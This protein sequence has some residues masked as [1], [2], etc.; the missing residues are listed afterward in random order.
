ML[1]PSQN[2]VALGTKHREIIPVPVQCLSLVLNTRRHIT[3]IKYPSLGN[4][5]VGQFD[6]RTIQQYDVNAVCLQGAHQ[7]MGESGVNL[8]LVGRAVNQHPQIIVAHW[9]WVAFAS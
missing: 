3:L 1:V 2:I 6:G 9:A 4:D 7:L 8:S 5:R